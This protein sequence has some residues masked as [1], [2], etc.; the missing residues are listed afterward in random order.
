MRLFALKLFGLCDNLHLLQIILRICSFIEK[1]LFL[2]NFWQ[3]NL[4]DNNV[5]ILLNVQ[6]MIILDEQ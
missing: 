6:K 2:L 5:Q 3:K 4:F 1:K